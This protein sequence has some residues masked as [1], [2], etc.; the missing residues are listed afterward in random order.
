MQKN[1]LI[2]HLFRLIWYMWACLICILTILSI[3][4]LCMNEKTVI[5]LTASPMPVYSLIYI[6]D[7]ISKLL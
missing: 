7:K 1:K 2:I 6:I 3:I 4:H 5:Y